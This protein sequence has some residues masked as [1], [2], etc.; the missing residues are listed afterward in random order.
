LGRPFVA[1]SCKRSEGST[2]DNPGAFVTQAVVCG[3]TAAEVGGVCSVPSKTSVI[4]DF[5]SKTKYSSHVC[6]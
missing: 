3:A 6:P 5:A 2:S 1:K 4:L